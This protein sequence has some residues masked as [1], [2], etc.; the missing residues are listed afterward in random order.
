[1]D[2]DIGT[3]LTKA[4]SRRVAGRLVR[5]Y[6]ALRLSAAAA[7]ASPLP[8]T[9]RADPAPIV[10]IAPAHAGAWDERE[11]VEVDG[12]PAALTIPLTTTGVSRGST[13][14]PN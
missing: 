8:T 12:V 11:C 6:M 3:T 4:R 14:S 9:V 1:M 13:L 7:S 2:R 10:R 5:Y